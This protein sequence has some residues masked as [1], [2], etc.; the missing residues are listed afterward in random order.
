MPI[1]R[2]LPPG[3]AFAFGVHRGEEER[4]CEPG[5][6]T[7]LDS[8]T[9]IQPLVL[10]AAAEAVRRSQAL[11]D[12]GLLV[13]AVRP[14]TVP[15]GSARL[16]ISLSAAHRIEDIERLLAALRESAR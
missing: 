3:S 9:A 15:H 6:G 11:A 13:P 16:R 2:L 14:P 5:C 4:E 12:R 7:L 1:D 8:Q 10:G